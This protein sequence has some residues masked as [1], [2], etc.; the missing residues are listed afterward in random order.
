MS[1]LAWVTTMASNSPARILVVDDDPVL[2]MHFAEVLRDKGYEVLEACDG[3]TALQAAQEK[4]PDLVLLDVLMPGMNGF[5]VCRALK[6][7]PDLSGIFVVIVSG[8]TTDESPES[9]GVDAGADDYIVKPVQ[10]HEFL[11]RVRFILRLRDTTVALRSALE[12]NQSLTKRIIA[13]QEVER[14]RVARDLHDS[15]N[16]MLASAKMR[17]RKVVDE[18]GKQLQPS[19]REILLRCDRLLVQALDENRRIAQNLRPGE[20]DALG[21]P[22]AC[23][24]LCARFAARTSIQVTCSASRSRRRFHQ[25]LELNLFRIL[26]EALNNVEKHSGATHAWVRLGIQK[27][28]ISLSIVDDGRGFDTSNLPRRGTA[29]VGLENMRERAEVLGAQLEL[30]SI[31]GKGTSINVVV[32][33]DQP[34]SEERARPGT[35]ERPVSTQQTA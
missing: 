6:Q 13:A 16:Q 7:N 5:E 19:A 4:R 34:K 18:C 17:L 11:A 21:L 25:E 33:I 8:Q 28:S 3:P 27:T 31:P 29:G 23:R 14:Q 10:L 22:E 15:V 32:P 26:Q 35:Q 9:W 1:W 2:R 24:G 12:L 30:S 20:L